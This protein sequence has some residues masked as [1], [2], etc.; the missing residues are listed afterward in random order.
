MVKPLTTYNNI[1]DKDFE[2][3]ESNLSYNEYKKMGNLKDTFK[4]KCIDK[5]GNITVFNIENAIFDK[6]GLQPSELKTVNILR[7]KLGWDIEIIHRI[8]VPEGIKCPDIRINK[9]EYWEIKNI[10][11]SKTI[12]SHSK[13]LSHRITKQCNNFIFDI[14]NDS[15]SLSNHE[16]M[17]QIYGIFNNKLYSNVNNIILIGKEDIIRKFEKK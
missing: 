5:D 16:A 1:K 11:A 8:N 15:C 4:Y 7:K 3:K 17:Q 2:I 10:Y 12:N 14:S 13:K 9:K 6:K